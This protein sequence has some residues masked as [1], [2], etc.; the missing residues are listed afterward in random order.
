MDNSKAR[1]FRRNFHKK[2][3]QNYKNFRR[4]LFENFCKQ[5][6]ALSCKITMQDLQSD[7]PSVVHFVSCNVWHS[8]VCCGVV[9]SGL[10]SV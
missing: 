7:V 5:K 2:L 3:M 6:N 1:K 10:H 4:K 8:V 9:H